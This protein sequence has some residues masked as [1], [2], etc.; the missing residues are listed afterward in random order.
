MLLLTENYPTA[1][2]CFLQALGRNVILWSDKACP[3]DVQYARV[4]LPEA[5][6]MWSLCLACNR[7]LRHTMVTA[8]EWPSMNNGV[9]LLNCGEH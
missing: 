2:S 5:R 7:H 3:A 9:V 4:T 8:K 6:A 1:A